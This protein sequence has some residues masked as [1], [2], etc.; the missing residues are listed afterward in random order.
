MPPLPS[1]NYPIGL[2]R[3]LIKLFLTPAL[4]RISQLKKRGF[5]VILR[6]IVQFL[7]GGRLR[8]GANCTVSEEYETPGGFPLHEN[9]RYF[10][11][12]V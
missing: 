11:W 2:Y 3:P 6:E 4:S 1:S 8:N 12:L 10:D 5:C 7:A 9:I